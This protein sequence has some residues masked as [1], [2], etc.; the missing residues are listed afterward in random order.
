MINYFYFDKIMEFF[1]KKL[2]FYEENPE[3]NKQN[4]N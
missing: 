3:K 1:E 2:S 4:N